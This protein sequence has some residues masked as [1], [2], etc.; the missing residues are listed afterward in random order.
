MS[1]FFKIRN[2]TFGCH[3]KEKLLTLGLMLSIFFLLFFR[4]TR[5]FIYPEPWIEDMCVFIAEEYKIGFPNTA[6]VDHAGYL[7]LFPRIIAWFSMKFGMSNV[8][9]IMNWTVL[10]IKVLIFYSI[11][12]SKEISSRLLKFSLLAYLVLLP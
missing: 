4:N 8:M 10:I 2:L 7:H 5:I 11:Y 6:I 1:D 12:S 3:L 9:I